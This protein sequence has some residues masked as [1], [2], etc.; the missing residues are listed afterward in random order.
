MKKI[1]NLFIII[2]AITGSLCAQVVREDTRIRARIGVAGDISDELNDFPDALETATKKNGLFLPINNF[3]RHLQISV[4]YESELS[5]RYSLLITVE[6]D[7]ERLSNS[8]VDTN[9]S[10]FQGIN[11]TILYYTVSMALVRY[12]PIFEVNLGSATAFIGAGAEL[13]YGNAEAGFQFDQRPVDLQ[14]IRFNKF[15]YAWGGRVFGGMEI[16]FMPSVFLQVR[17]GLSIRNPAKFD[18]KVKFNKNTPIDPEI[19]RQFNNFNFS[20]VWMNLGLAYRF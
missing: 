19:F 7:K 6:Y 13:L 9:N 5:R 15:G 2:A 18:G 3:N 11:Y 1:M 14:I 17:A 10:I 20:S 4:E 12:F 16:P 8:S